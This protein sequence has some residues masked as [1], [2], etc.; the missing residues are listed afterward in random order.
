MIVSYKKEIFETSFGSRN[1][2][3]LEVLKGVKFTKPY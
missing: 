1:L 3:V 2:I